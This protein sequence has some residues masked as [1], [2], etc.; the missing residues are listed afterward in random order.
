MAVPHLLIF[1]SLLPKQFQVTIIIKVVFVLTMPGGK[2]KLMVFQAFGPDYCAIGIDVD[3]F[4][5]LRSLFRFFVIS[6]NPSMSFFK[7]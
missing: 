4:V 3:F 1:F 6:K 7:N 2:I 5:D